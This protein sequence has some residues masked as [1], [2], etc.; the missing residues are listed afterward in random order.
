MNHIIFALLGFQNSIWE[1]LS[2]RILGDF[3]RFK[4]VPIDEDLSTPGTY[5]ILL[6]NEMQMIGLKR[7]YTNVVGI[8][9]K[10]PSDELSYESLFPYQ[11]TSNEDIQQIY[12]NLAA[13][14]FREALEGEVTVI[15]GTMVAG[16]STVAR[17]LAVHLGAFLV[18]YEFVVRA[19][20]YELCFERQFRL[21][22][23]HFMRNLKSVEETFDIKKTSRDRD[24][25]HSEAIDKLFPVWSKRPEIQESAIWIMMRAYN[26]GYTRIVV[27]GV[28]MAIYPF[29]RANH[30]F[31][32]ECPMKEQVKRFSSKNM[33]HPTNS[34]KAL[35]EANETQL[36]L[37]YS[38]LDIVHIDTLQN[39]QNNTFTQIITRVKAA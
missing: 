20:I 4:V 31:F 25:L 19:I 38:T 9:L 23:K 16:K 33:K 17:R 5:I 29:P 13:I 6:E 21:H 26:T 10:Q 18:E 27:E 28:G 39:G 12:I 8:Y 2:R 24:E 35:K 36:R 32:L 30:K 11:F 22:D 7:A 15:D 1:E 3:P 37:P 34:R 14:F